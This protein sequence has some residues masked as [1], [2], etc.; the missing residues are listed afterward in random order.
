M[1]GHTLLERYGMTEIG[2]AL[3]NPYEDKSKRLPGH[4]GKTFPGVK[5][6]FFD[7][8]ANEIL[9]HSSDGHELL[10]QSKSMFDRYLNNEEATEDTFVTCPTTGEK[11]FK[12]GDMAARSDNGAFRILGRL[13]MDIIK[14]QGYKISALEIEGRLIQHD[15]VR[16]SA[17]I[18]VP[19]EEYG[20]EIVAFVVPKEGKSIAP[21]ELEAYVR[22]HMSS[23]K[24]P[25][26]WKILDKIPRNHMGKI[27]KNELKKMFE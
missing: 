11:W 27:S 15:S 7:N 8:E 16:E 5:A 19:S 4:V 9:S 23:Y 12:T 2:M 17:V 21:S 6:A 13:S 22:E 20:E 25:R 24:I 1:T 3:T 10:I 26:E 18:G 14:K